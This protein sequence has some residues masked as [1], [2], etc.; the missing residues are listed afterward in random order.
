MAAS[1]ADAV[2]VDME[3]SDVIGGEGYTRRLTFETG[4]A[5]AENQSRTAFRP[6]IEDGE[7]HGAMIGAMTRE[8]ILAFAT[9]DWAALAEAKADYWARRKKTMTAEDALAVAEGLRRRARALRPGWPDDTERAADLAVHVRISEA[10]G[11]VA[12]RHT[13]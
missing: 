9:R 7:G 12:R 8:E 4:D 10:L 5:H 2:A 11:A 6:L 3:V 1:L 13:R